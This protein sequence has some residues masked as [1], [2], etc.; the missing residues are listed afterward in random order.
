MR[1]KGRSRNEGDLPGS[2]RPKAKNALEYCPAGAS[3]TGRT[4]TPSHH[5]RLAPFPCLPLPPPYR[6]FLPSLAFH[7]LL[8]ILNTTSP[9][10]DRDVAN[11]RCYTGLAKCSRLQATS[12]HLL[13]RH[14]CLASIVPRRSVSRRCLTSAVPLNNTATVCHTKTCACR[15]KCVISRDGFPPSSKPERRN[16]SRSRTA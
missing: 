6:S 14:Y 10:L 7:S 8:G 2:V 16:G 1:Q 13:L 4:A 12:I 3:W 9:A 15:V 5:S 11:T